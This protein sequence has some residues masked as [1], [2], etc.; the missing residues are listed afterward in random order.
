MPSKTSREL[1]GLALQ[2]RVRRY[3]THHPNTFNCQRRV[4]VETR[5]SVFGFFDG[6][7]GRGYKAGVGEHNPDGIEGD[8][9][10]VEEEEDRGGRD[11]TKTTD[12][13]LVHR[14]MERRWAYPERSETGSCTH[15]PPRSKYLKHP[16]RRTS[17]YSSVRCHSARWLRNKVD[18]T[19]LQPQTGRIMRRLE[20]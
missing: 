6:S 8:G 15:L 1:Y 19:H 11:A 16:I 2:T 13:L 9:E 12:E 20:Y 5:P 3:I 4:L 14:V 17:R 18:M 10:E 7:V